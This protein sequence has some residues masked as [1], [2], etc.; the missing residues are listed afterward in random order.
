MAPAA[1]AAADL[2]LLTLLLSKVVCC[3]EDGSG[4]DISLVQARHQEGTEKWAAAVRVLPQG[5]SCWDTPKPHTP[6]PFQDHVAHVLQFPLVL[7]P[8]QPLSPFLNSTACKL[9]TNCV[10]S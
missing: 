1:A 3:S 6:R 4:G 10:T 8:R 9:P 7:H 2:V 5:G